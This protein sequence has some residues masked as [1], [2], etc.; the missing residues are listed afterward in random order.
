[1][2]DLETY[3]KAFSESDALNMQWSR[4]HD[5]DRV[6]RL[7]QNQEIQKL[8]EA[9]IE[10]RDVFDKFCIQEDFVYEE[11]FDQKCKLDAIINEHSKNVNSDGGEE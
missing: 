7:R 10:A 11:S 3:K 5:A 4:K 9:L 6:V 1:M 8:K 2:S